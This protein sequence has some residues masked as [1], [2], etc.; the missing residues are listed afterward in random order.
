MPAFFVPEARA[1]VKLAGLFG[2]AHKGARRRRFGNR[3][4]A[5]L[6][7]QTQIGPHAV[8]RTAAR[9]PPLRL[10]FPKHQTRAHSM[11]RRRF[12]ALVPLLNGGD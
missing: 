8:R 12:P 6:P 10:R 4:T 5:L 7:F 2:Y 11:P 1:A 9:R 3:Q